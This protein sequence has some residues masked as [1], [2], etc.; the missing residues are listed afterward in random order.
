ML[1]RPTL[2]LGAVPWEIKPI[3]AALE[4]RR[5]GKLRNFPFHEGRLGGAEVVLAITGVGK[6]NAAM[7]A[8]L[9]IEHFKPGRLIY[10]GSAARLN[11]EL[12]T[13][14]VIIG[15]RTFHHDAGSWQEDGML[16]RKIIGP[17]AGRPTHYRFDADRGLLKAALAAAKTHEPKI[18]TANGAT[19]RPAVRAGLICSGDV[20]GM[21]AAKV[22]DIRAKLKCDLVEMEGSAVGQ[23]CH[24]LGVPHLVIRGGS[25]RA[26]PSPGEDYKRLGQIAARQAAFFAM[27]LVRSL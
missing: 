13:G 3:V 2:L 5:S 17:A 15:R 9:F 27:H 18:V 21:T 6:T 12:R 16:Y 20:F 4:R 26:Q 23:V 25:N 1:H 19:Y 11:P 10:T 8:T 14:D 7:I 22:A 24:E